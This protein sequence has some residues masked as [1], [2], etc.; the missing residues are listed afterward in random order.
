MKA[1]GVLKNIGG[2]IIV[3]AVNIITNLILPPMIITFYGSKINGLIGTITQIISYVSLVGAGLSVATTQALY[4]PLAEKDKKTVSG[5]MKA[6]G[7]MFNHVG[8]LFVCFALAISLIYP[9]FIKGESQYIFVVILMLVM[10]L[11]GAM[12]FF[13]TGRYRSLLY[14][15]RKIYVYSLIQSACLVISTGFAIC[16]IKF[17]LS[18]IYTQA[19]ISMVYVLRALG[20]ALYVKK[21]YPY[22]LNDSEPINECINK[23]KDAMYHQFIGLIVTGSQS[24]LLSIFVGLEAASIY[25]VYNVVFSG[26]HSVCVQVSNAVVPYIGRVYAIGKKEEVNKKYGLFEL[27]FFIFITVIIATSF[28]MIQSFINL[29]TKGADI[30]YVDTVLAVMFVARGFSSM[31]RLPA[32]GLINA[33]GYFAETKK[34]ATIEAVICVIIELVCVQFWGI[35]GIMAGNLVAL[36]WRGFEMVFFTNKN[37]IFRGNKQSIV[38]ITQTVFTILASYFIV[39]MI[40]PI[41]TINSWFQWILFASAS[42]CISA[43]IT[44]LVFITTERKNI[45]EAIHMFI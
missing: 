32:Q 19:M 5:M 29:Y 20:L 22:L 18:I 26:L 14:A 9:L 16:C 30:E 8:W 6:T 24:I 21:K 13:A 45:I 2:S 28:I 34:A 33:A 11:S 44:I 38:R 1:R 25:G 10:S 27:V 35:Y 23:R 43:F 37:I 41:T 17:N 40:F 3:Q 39:M 15:D 36:V 4:K 42:V 31:F 12:E 7:I